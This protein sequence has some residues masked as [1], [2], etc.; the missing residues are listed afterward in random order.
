[1]GHVL[2]EESIE[3]G[4]LLLVR[5]HEVPFGD[6]ELA[7]IFD[8]VLVSL[9]LERTLSHAL[10]FEQLDS[11]IRGRTDSYV[12]QVRGTDDAC[13]TLACMAVHKDL[14]L[15]CNRIVFHLLAD[16]EYLLFACRF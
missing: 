2:I 11:L 14:H 1:M 4:N 5:V 15:L 3:V 8:T 10:L 6:K 16:H 13:A 7:E 9:P 12:E